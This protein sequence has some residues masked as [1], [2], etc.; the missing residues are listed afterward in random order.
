L[1]DS[2]VQCIPT[3]MKGPLGHG[4]SALLLGCSS[5]TRKGLFVLPGVIDA[6]FEGI[7]SIMVW[8]PIPP[9]YIPKGAKI[10]Q[11]VPFRAVVPL[12]ENCIRG[13]GGF[14]S[15]G[16]LEV[17]LAM[18]IIKNKPIEQVVLK[19]P[20]GNTCTLNMLIDTGADVTIVS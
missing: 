7:I 16:K 11:L 10:G 14:G 6:D 2:Q 1:I 4:L 20:G 9:V 5:V 12:A 17:Y 18:D 19:E 13:T 8:S 3:N 15:T